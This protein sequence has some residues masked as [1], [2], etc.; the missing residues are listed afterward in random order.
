[1]S[2]LHLVEA[3]GGLVR[4][5]E[6]DP[7]LGVRIDREDDCAL[8]AVR[9][10]IPCLVTLHAGPLC[11]SGSASLGDDSA[12]GE[13]TRPDVI[14]RS[15]SWAPILNVT[16]QARPGPEVRSGGMVR[17]GGDPSRSRWRPWWS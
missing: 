7:G 12:P 10:T 9:P 15:T 1:P 2:L 3:G 8:G 13:S 17:C 11:E 14:L 6:D 16:V 4:L 5:A